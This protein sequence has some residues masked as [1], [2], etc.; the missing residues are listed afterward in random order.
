ML[1]DLSHSAGVVPLNLSVADMAVGCGYKYLNGG[2]GAPAFLY[3]R[4]ELQEQMTNP[5]PGWF[6]TAN[7]FAF[8]VN[9]ESAPG[10]QRFQISTPNVLSMTAMEA[11]IDLYLE[12]GADLIWQKAV[13]LT[14]LFIDSVEAALPEVF[15]LATPKD[16]DQRGAHVTLKHS[17]AWRINQALNRFENVIPDYREPDGVR[18]GFSPLT[19]SY[20]EVAAAVERLSRIM[21]TKSYEQLPLQKPAVT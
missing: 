8:N 15:T 6:G 1:W 10:I 4:R 14:S 12:A 18:F 17:E 19:T 2:P 5:I 13:G 21:Q 7:P 11:G 20:R 16:P 3:V 9:Y